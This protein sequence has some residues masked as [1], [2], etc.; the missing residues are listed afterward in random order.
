M[1]TISILISGRGSNLL[2]ILS[3][4][5]EGWIACNVG[6]VI[7]NNPNARGLNFVPSRIPTKVVEYGKSVED[8]K[9][10]ETEIDKTLREVGTDFVILAGFNRIL[11][12]EFIEKWKNKVVNIHPS[13]LPAF[14]G[15]NAQKQAFEYGAAITGCTV[16]FVDSGVDTG[17]IIA[18]RHVYINSDDTVE[19]VS[20]KILRNENDLYPLVILWLIEDRL[21]IEGKRVKISWPQTN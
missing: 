16:H 5:E 8:R 18:Q 13:L 7:S 1:K 6:V 11:S 2:A 17:P 4:I 3:A 14:P 12:S 20:D 10:A 9:T 15:M 19:T 21:T